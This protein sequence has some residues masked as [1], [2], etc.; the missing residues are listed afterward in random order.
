MSR[1]LIYLKAQIN[2]LDLEEEN[3]VNIMHDVCR[4]L[5]YLHEQRV[6][7]RDLKPEN[8]MLS[9]QGFPCKAKITDFGLARILGPGESLTVRTIEA[10]VHVFTVLHLWCAVILWNTRFYRT[11]SRGISV[12]DSRER[13]LG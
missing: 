12:G 7:H 5:R 6:I 1:A 13:I 10:S 2:N 4:G 8:I 9:R 3:C 11:G